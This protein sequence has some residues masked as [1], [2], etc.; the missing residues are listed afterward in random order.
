MVFCKLPGV[1]SCT[2]HA[3]LKNKITIVL[4]FFCCCDK[5]P[6]QK[7]PKEGRVYISLQFQKTR[8]QLGSQ[9]LA[10]GGEGIVE[11]ASWLIYHAHTGSREVKGSR[12]H[13]QNPSSVLYFLHK[14]LLPNVS[15]IFSNIAT[16]W[17]PST[18]IY[19]Y[20][21]DISHIYHINH[22]HIICCFHVPFS[23][24]FIILMKTHLIV[25]NYL[26]NC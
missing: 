15:I 4:I 16:S 17:G 11:A 10:V 1:Y 6:G 8:V 19:E 20:M 3:H 22:T 21:G 7:Q 24:N 9:G 2:K 26:P 12:V 13:S 25:Y 18:Q 14:T 23:Y 5:I